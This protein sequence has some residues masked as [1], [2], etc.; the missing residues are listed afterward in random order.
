METDE[1]SI[2]LWRE[3]NLWRKAVVR[4]EAKLARLEKLHG[5]K[6]QDF[7]ETCAKGQNRLG[8]RET[9]EWLDA[10]TELDTA[11]ARRD[12]Y[13]GLYNKMKR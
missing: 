9:L 7:I 2:T 1:Y 3:F 4:A 11:R 5:M 10:R 8:Q 12:E 13:D 6:T